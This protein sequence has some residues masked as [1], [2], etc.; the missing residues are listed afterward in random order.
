MCI[1]TRAASQIPAA[2]AADTK[3][4]WTFLNLLSVTFTQWEE[5]CFFKSHQD[6]EAASWGAGAY[7]FLHFHEELSKWKPKPWSLTLFQPH[8]EKPAHSWSPLTGKALCAATTSGCPPDSEG[9]SQSQA[10]WQT[11]TGESFQIFEGCM[12]YSY[13]LSGP[14][15]YSLAEAQTWHAKEHRPLMKGQT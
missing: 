14:A 8:R 10:P 15:I 4:G 9:L 7:R 1:W 13:N 6:N 5:L 3:G 11:F 12:K 2:Q